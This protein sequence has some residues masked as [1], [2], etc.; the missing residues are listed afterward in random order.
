MSDSIE[1]RVA[2]LEEQASLEKQLIRGTR[3]TVDFLFKR[4]VERS[5]PSEEIDAAMATASDYRA[6]AAFLT[7][8]FVGLII[9]VFI[10]NQ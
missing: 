9:A 2:K 3:D 10:F 7:G 8:I 6:K 5:Y 4:E 1:Q